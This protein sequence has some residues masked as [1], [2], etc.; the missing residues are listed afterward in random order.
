MRTA[1][2]CRQLAQIHHMCITS[3]LVV[4]DAVEVD[5]WVM[6]CSVLV[7]DSRSARPLIRSQ[8]RVPAGRALPVGI[9]SHVLHV[10]FPRQL[11]RLELIRQRPDHGRVYAPFAQ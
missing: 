4:E 8:R 6:L 10:T 1:K 2:V 11:R 3:T 5:E 9:V 7:T